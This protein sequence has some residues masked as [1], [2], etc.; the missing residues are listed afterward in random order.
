MHQLQTSSAEKSESILK[1][2][3]KKET[4]NREILQRE[5]LQKEQMQK[6][7]EVAQQVEKIDLNAIAAVGKKRKVSDL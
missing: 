3:Y 2:T 4:L 1:D 6:A 5:T 7:H